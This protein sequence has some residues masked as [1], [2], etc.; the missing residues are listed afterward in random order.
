MPI[1]NE[2]KFVLNDDGGLEARIGAALASCAACCS[3]PIWTQRA[4]ASHSSEG[5]RRHEPCLHLQMHGRRPGRRDRDPID[6]RDFER[7]WS[8]RLQSLKGALLVARRRLSLGRRLLPARRRQHLLRPGR[9][10]D[11]GRRRSSHHRCRPCWRAIC[12]RRCRRAIR[13]SPP[14]T[15][16]DQSHAERLLADIRLK[17]ELNE[18]RAHRQPFDQGAFHLRWQPDRLWRAQWTTNNIL[19]VRVE[20]DSGLVGWGEAFC[21]GCTDAVRAAL[22]NM[23][24]PLAVGEDASDIARL[25]YDLQQAPS[26]R[27]IRPH[28]LRAVR[29]RHRAVG[30]RRQGGGPAAGSA[31][32]AAAAAPKL[33]A[34]ASLLKYRDPEKV[35][36]P[37]LAV[38]QGYRHQA[39]RDRG[40]RGQGGRGRRATTSPSWSIPTVRGRQSRRA[41]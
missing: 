41:S 6:A 16:T 18:D 26:V 36:A 21:Y 11:A 35:A 37:R 15:L 5:R 20:T 3:K 23:V 28:H 27:P 2:R 17:G 13:A 22:H 12:W 34:Y 14:G 40:A 1:E 29:A 24:A 32:P 9:G 31:S 10:R 33:P 19:L 8:K 7:L 39:A 30:H 4:F 38:Q 25:S